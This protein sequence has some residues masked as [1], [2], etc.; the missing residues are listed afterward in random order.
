MLGVLLCCF[1]KLP[2]IKPG[3][4][5]DDP[6]QYDR[7][8]PFAVADDDIGRFL[9]EVFDEVDAFEDVSQLVQQRIDLRVHLLPAFGP[10]GLLHH[11][12]VAFGQGVVFVAVS[13]ISVGGDSRRPQQLVGDASQGGHD[14]DY[15]FVLRLDNLFDIQDAF[16]GTYGCSA[17]FQY[18]HFLN[19]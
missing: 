8:H 3:R 5:F 19:K 16:R 6:V 17:K 18:F 14:D 12:A 11:A 10:D 2:G 15:R 4:T 13:G 1:D 7:G 9:R